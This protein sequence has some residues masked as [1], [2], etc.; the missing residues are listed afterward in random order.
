MITMATCLKKDTIPIPDVPMTI[1]EII[2]DYMK[3]YH[4]DEDLTRSQLTSLGD[5]VAGV[6][7]DSYTAN[8]F[9]RHPHQH[10]VE[11]QK[12]L[13]LIKLLQSLFKMRKNGTVVC[14]IGQ[15]TDFEDL[16][17]LVANSAN[18][19]GIFSK[20]T[21]IIYDTCYRIGCLMEPM[22]LPEAH[23]YVHSA[24]RQS[25]IILFDK[26]GWPRG[27]DK[28]RLNKHYRIPRIYFPEPL[29]SCD[30]ADIEAILC[31][32]NNKF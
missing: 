21:L 29:R 11:T 26:Y 23:V 17:E 14:D 15:L 27:W 24:P 1:Q 5:C 6:H 30:S 8:G 12:M 18:N 32:Y 31:I 16:F 19:A 3:N 22:I 7:N 2:D 25:S 13:D 28:T 20:G 10:D 4:V 9:Q